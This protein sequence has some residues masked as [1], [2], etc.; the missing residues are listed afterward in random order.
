MN[1]RSPGFIQII[2]L[3]AVV[4]VAVSVLAISLEPKP[5]KSVG[6][7]I[8]SES[9]SGGGEDDR[10]ESGGESG[11]GGSESSNDSGS[12]VK[13][14]QTSP[15]PSFSGKDTRKTSTR[16]FKPAETE[17]PEFETEDEDE[18]EALELELELEDESEVE[19]HEGTETAKLRI[20]KRKAK[21]AVLDQKFGAESEFPLS[22]DKVTNELIITTPQGIRVV[23]I[24]PDTAVENMLRQKLIDQIQGGNTQGVEI[25]ID[26]NGNVFYE[27]SGQRH[28]KLFGIFGIEVPKTL[29]VSAQTGDVIK[30]DQ[31]PLS[32]FL[33]ALSL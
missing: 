18:D 23:A 13:P 20:G 21:F 9:E 28:K 19:V 8:L 26:K 1:K 14:G 7:A 12:E 25:K 30:T 6:T 17:E 10:E 11:R 2:P 29:E 16:V 27:V 31:T 4:F 33:D 22:V 32:L 3:L 24:L 15:S 5:Q